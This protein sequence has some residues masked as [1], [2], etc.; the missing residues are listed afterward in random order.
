MK[1]ETDI[2]DHRLHKFDSGNEY[3][4]VQPN[5][6]ML[7]KTEANVELCAR[8][9]FLCL[10]DFNDRKILKHL[11]CTATFLC[12][13]MVSWILIFPSSWIT[14]HSD[15]HY[16][17]YHKVMKLMNLTKI[18]P[19]FVTKY[20][21]HTL[22][23]FTHNLP[24]ALWA[25]AIPFQLNP[26]VRRKYP[27]LH[28]VTGYLF[29]GTS[30]LMSYGIIVI[31]ARQLTFLHDFPINVATENFN[32]EF[33]CVNL[34]VISLTCWFV[35]TAFTAIS[36]IRS[37]DYQSHRNF[38]VRHIGSGIWVALQRI[39]FGMCNIA[40]L[41]ESPHEIKYSF[42]A[43]ACA[44]V[45]ISVLTSEFVIHLLKRQEFALKQ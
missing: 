13:Y 2:R 12:L 26:D 25:G 11:Y 10:S 19:Q 5:S 3:Y 33:W 36:K 35:F 28:K 43:A 30:F 31:L 6:N 38:I 14:G 15:I 40:G 9:N 18:P 8:T 44:G 39:I 20:A 29:L 42:K 1:T 32:F 45:V 16:A 37:R 7:D 27:R 41:S 23:Q 34:S 24:G 4:Q 21:G 22:V 17:Y